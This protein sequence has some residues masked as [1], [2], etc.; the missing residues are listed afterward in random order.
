MKLRVLTSNLW[1]EVPHLQQRTS[2][3][4]TAITTMNLD[5]MSFQELF[6]PVARTTFVAGF[7]KDYHYITA[8]HTLPA[9]PLVAYFP[10]I[11]AM[12]L[13]QG[14][15][16]LNDH[17]SLSLYVLWALFFAP[18]VLFLYF[19]FFMK[20]IL[21]PKP[22]ASTGEHD[23]FDFMGTAI[24]VKKSVFRSITPLLITPFSE[25][26]REYLYPKSF[27]PLPW[28][29]WWFQTSFL[30]SGFMLA[31]ATLHDGTTI[32]IVNCHLVVG[33]DN[34]SRMRQLTH[35]RQTLEM[36]NSGGDVFGEAVIWTGDFNADACKEEART[37]KKVGFKDAAED[38]GDE[39]ITWSQA[40]PYVSSD[41]TFI[42]EDS[43]MRIDYIWYTP[44]F[45][46]VVSCQR[47][48]DEKPFSDHYGIF[49][50]L[51]LEGFEMMDEGE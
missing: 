22:P 44:K 31:R 38:I 8:N 16:Y 36:Y 32:K 11:L 51:Q 6:A 41:V 25:Y 43:D 21:L 19:V 12:A 33:D 26:D 40:N 10:M 37:L 14:Y 13:I 15:L 47:V 18:Q 35:V 20:N 39:C 46:S 28:I 34:P 30:R 9:F 29:V 49:A 23:A 48:F 27:L 50:V 2:E 5:I 17:H 1:G 7:S 45:L 4:L 24:F 42:M 3:A